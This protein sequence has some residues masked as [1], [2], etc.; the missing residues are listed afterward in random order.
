MVSVFLREQKRYNQEELVKTFNMT[1][2]KTVRVLKRLKEYGILKAVKAEDA[3]RE[4]TELIED[5]VEI[6]DVEEGENAYYYVFTFVGVVTLENLILKCYPKYIASN[7]API[8]ELKQVL[9]VLSKY[10]SKEEII[11]MYNDTSNST[12]FNMLAVMLYLLNDYHEYGPYTNTEDIVETNGTGEILW[13]KTINETFTL[14]SGNRPYYPELMTRKNVVDEYD[15]FK[16]LHECVVT[17]CSKELKSA[18]LLDLFDFAGV[19]VSDEELSDFGDTE[20]ILDSLEKELNIQFNTR[21]QLVLKTLYAY[22]SNNSKAQGLDCFSMFGTNSFNL[23]WEKVCAEVLNNQLDTKLSSLKIK[24][25]LSSTFHKHRGEKLIDII[26]RPEW[27][28]NKTNRTY[29]KE[30]LIPDLISVGFD[31]NKGYF[32]LFDAK[33][34]C[35]SANNN[36]LNGNPGIES[37]TKQYLYQQAYSD[38]IDEHGLEVYNSFLFPTEKTEV[39]NL[40]SVKLGMMSKLDL[41]DIL[42]RE[43]PAEE[44][45]T[46]YLKNKHKNPIEVLS[47]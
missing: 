35:V 45:Y 22:V 3:Q 37:V 39:G 32:A 41:K 42:L 40:G 8:K 7:N 9:K 4:L 30:T 20:Y 38:F 29:S 19:D 5:D 34:Y 6:A 1:E 47:L 2:E 25:G 24:G 33:Y 31:D 17:Q 44:M 28:I 12:A 46:C 27:Y 43:L 10:N 36:S 15:Y 26:D 16:R 23:V 11:K 14:I 13:D 18:D 21:K